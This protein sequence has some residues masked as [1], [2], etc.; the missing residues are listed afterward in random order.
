MI[1]CLPFPDQPLPGTED[2]TIAVRGKLYDRETLATRLAQPERSDLSSLLKHAWRKWGVDCPTCLNGDF[3]FLLRDV[4]QSIIFGARDHIGARP[5]YYALTRDGI[6]FS[7]HA[8]DLLSV[9]GVSDSPDDDWLTDFLWQ[10]RSEAS[11]TPWRD[12][13]VLP[14]GCTLTICRDRKPVIR[15][16]WRPEDAAEVRFR[17]N[18]EYRDAFLDLHERAIADRLPDD[19]PVGAH[20]SGG[21]D[22]S[23]IA[24]RAAR[25][26][27]ADTVKC[28]AW[29]PLPVPGD[30]PA[31]E[32]KWLQ[33]L[34]DHTGLPVNMAE[35]DQQS[36]RALMQGTIPLTPQG[37]TLF[38]EGP[39]MRAAAAQGIRIMLSGWGG[40]EAI[41][42]NGNGYFEDLLFNFRLRALMQYAR[43]TGRGT[44]RS[45]A[46]AVR[47]VAGKRLMLWRERRAKQRKYRKSILIPSLHAWAGER[48]QPFPRVRNIRQVQR[49]FY[50]AN[51]ITERMQAWAAAARP[52]GL[53]YRYPLTDRRIMEFAYGLPPEQFVQGGHRRM[54]MRRAMA[55]LLPGDV[56]WS[57]NKMEPLRVEI[58]QAEIARAVT[59]A[60]ADMMASPAPSATHLIDPDRAR[61]LLT[62]GLGEHGQPGRMI[63]TL[64]VWNG[65]FYNAA[66]TS[67]AN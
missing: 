45:L 53:E 65:N 1:A 33:S 59:D 58:Y 11:R 10:Q 22:C 51:H 34:S 7:D 4:R 9:D 54:L 35:P 62:G 57:N 50:Y 16:Y 15:R 64:Q 18:D 43:G 23:G 19:G 37:L 25:L 41:S 40:D 49:H 56:A 17:S 28:Y 47:A 38:H 2:L 32:Q 36:I 21:L 14:A 27:P 60:L 46:G 44:A 55:T 13:H 30:K 20:F 12:I 67:S 8:P 52:L 39:V 24:A 29:Q 6:H 66:E 26:R 3:A 5:F 31:P 61:Q 42:H 63:R 48:E